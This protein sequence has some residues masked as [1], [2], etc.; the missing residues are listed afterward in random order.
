MRST[1][2]KTLLNPKRL[3]TSTK[4]SMINKDSRM[5]FKVLKK[6]SGIKLDFSKML[7]QRKTKF[8]DKFNKGIKIKIKRITRLVSLLRA[9]S[10]I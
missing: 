4:I 10:I 9:S 7:S 1:S 3:S 8:K 2:I 6:I 5:R